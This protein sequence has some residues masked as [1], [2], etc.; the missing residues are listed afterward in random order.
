MQKKRR[1][2]ELPDNERV[3]E[4][5]KQ[6]SKLQSAS[7]FKK[8]VDVVEFKCANYYELIKSPMDLQTMGQRLV[9]GY[10]A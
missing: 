4:F 10:L 1:E 3:F 5:L 6:L 2:K 9:A 8:P 7:F